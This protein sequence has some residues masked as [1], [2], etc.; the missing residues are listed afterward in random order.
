MPNENK[1]TIRVKDA[2]EAYGLSRASFY[3]MMKDGTIKPRKV[4][5]CVFLAVAELDELFLGKQSA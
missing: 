5:G 2:I 4:G 3:R 1:K